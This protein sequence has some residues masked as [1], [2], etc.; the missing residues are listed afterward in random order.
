MHKNQDHPVPAIELLDTLY[1]TFPT[2]NPIDNLNFNYF[3]LKNKE[4]RECSEIKT[5]LGM[6]QSY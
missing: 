6:I 4:R 2:C 1:V 5:P 3:A